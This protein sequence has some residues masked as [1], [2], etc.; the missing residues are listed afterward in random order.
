MSA[1]CIIVCNGVILFT[2]I[3]AYV[4]DAGERSMS[5]TLIGDKD[6]TLSR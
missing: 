4:H 3:G 1:E 6:L 2:L 5:V